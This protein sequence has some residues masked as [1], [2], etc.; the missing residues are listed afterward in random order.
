M[1]L[2]TYF[3]QKPITDHSSLKYFNSLLS[4]PIPRLIKE[5]DSNNQEIQALNKQMKQQAMSESKEFIEAL[6]DGKDLLNIGKSISENL[7]DALEQTKGLSQIIDQ[8][9]MKIEFNLQE[10]KKLRLIS[11]QQNTIS[12][13]LD[14]P[15]LLKTLLNAH[16]YNESLVL[17]N[18]VEN[19][20]NK[21][22]SPTFTGLWKSLVEIKNK[23]LEDIIEQMT[24]TTDLDKTSTYLSVIKSIKNCDN[25]EICKLYLTSKRKFLDKKL[26]KQNSPKLHMNYYLSMLKDNLPK[27]VDIFQEKFAEFHS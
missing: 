13:I 20:K 12:E 24:D 15:L 26:Q 21:H 17:I 18:F 25:L 6:G 4:Y 11:T 2:V 27:I 1:S 10:Q 23:I 9:A 3:L 14:I 22:E 7:M 8:N 16:H 5:Q 19:L